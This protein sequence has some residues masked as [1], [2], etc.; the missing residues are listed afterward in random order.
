MLTDSTL[1]FTTPAS[2]APPCPTDL[3]TSTAPTPAV[4]PRDGVDRTA[5]TLVGVHSLIIIASGVFLAAVG[6]GM[7]AAAALIEG[8][9]RAV[10]AI[11]IARRSRV[12]TKVALGHSYVSAVVSALNPPVG[13]LFTLLNVVIVRRLRSRR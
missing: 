11:G 7:F 4:A 13:V 8:T 6:E 10:E 3:L 1:T 2:F 12:L 5:L 9:L